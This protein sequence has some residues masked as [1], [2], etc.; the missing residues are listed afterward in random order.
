MRHKLV[1]TIAMPAVAAAV[2][3]VGAQPAR[4]DAAAPADVTTY[5]VSWEVHAPGDGSSPLFAG[6]DMYEAVSA[7]ANN[8]GVGVAAPPTLDLGG[9]ALAR[10]ASSPAGWA[11]SRPGTDSRS[12]VASGSSAASYAPPPTTAKLRRAEVRV[13]TRVVPSYISR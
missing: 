4:A 12:P 6:M 8:P 7:T 2:L 13:W 3:L 5:T 10:Y 1:S 11:T 9:A